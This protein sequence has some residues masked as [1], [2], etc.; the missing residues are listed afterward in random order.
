MSALNSDLATALA[1]SVALPGPSTTTG[2]AAATKTSGE[3]KT[4]LVS[5][6]QAQAIAFCNLA[7]GI[8]AARE[9]AVL[10]KTAPQHDALLN[11]MFT[12]PMKEPVGRATAKPL[13]ILEWTVANNKD[14][15][16]QLATWFMELGAAA[17]LANITYLRS[18][19]DGATL[20]HESVGNIDKVL[21]GLVKAFDVLMGDTV[22][23]AYFTTLKASATVLST[24]TEDPA[25]SNKQHIEQ[26]KQ[27]IAALSSGDIR[28]NL[29]KI[30]LLYRVLIDLEAKWRLKHTTT[31]SPQHP[32]YPVTTQVAQSLSEIYPGQSNKTVSLTDVALMLFGGPDVPGLLNIF[33]TDA[34]VGD[35]ETPVNEGLQKFLD[36]IIG[37]ATTTMASA[38]TARVKVK[39][40]T[41]PALWLGLNQY[42]HL[43][44]LV[45]YAAGHAFSCFVT[46][47]QPMLASVSLSTLHG[48]V[49]STLKYISHVV[50]ASDY[51][52][53]IAVMNPLNAAVHARLKA[54]RGLSTQ[55]DANLVLVALDSFHHENQAKQIASY[56]A[57]AA[58]PAATRGGGGS[59]GSSG[60]TKT[61]HNSNTFRNLPP[62]R[63]IAVAAVTS[64]TD[65]HHYCMK[66]FNGVGG[67]TKHKKVTD[68]CKK[69]TVNKALTDAAGRVWQ[70][71]GCETAATPPVFRVH[72]KA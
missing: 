1:L 4:S 41:V 2:N 19:P 3:T 53:G 68:T 62:A 72:T 40:M 61:Q 63:R 44:S 70:C 9:L 60:A 34:N 39:D 33:L 37:T 58:A 5:E 66:Y 12:Q 49:S 47:L 15:I 22:T 23:S 57:V 32:L 43:L 29:G 13:P 30:T 56:L 55:I 65:V 46:Q 27:N 14:H 7:A 35:A 31:L 21:S 17:A 51:T 20:M 48:L 50:V 71:V 26:L 18:M 45:S 36:T 69:S 52:K 28:D 6:A 16:G 67:K 59:G 11:T 24:G 54:I 10:C 25:S 64:N 8:A 38:T 42:K